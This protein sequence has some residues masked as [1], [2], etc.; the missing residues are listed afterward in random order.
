[1]PLLYRVPSTVL[2]TEAR[3]MRPFLIVF[4][5]SL[6]SSLSLRMESSTRLSRVWRVLSDAGD[7][8]GRPAA[9]TSWWTASLLPTLNTKIAMSKLSCTYVAELR[10]SLS[11]MLQTNLCRDSFAFRV[12]PMAQESRSAGDDNRVKRGFSS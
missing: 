3:T 4:R 2:N 11:A 6:T 10:A 8:Y 5:L 7:G 9:S 12:T 1:M